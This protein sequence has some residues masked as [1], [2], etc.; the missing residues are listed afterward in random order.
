V[1]KLNPRGDLSLFLVLVLAGFAIASAR[2]ANASEAEQA[3]VVEFGPVTIDGISAIQMSWWF[4]HIADENG[5]FFNPLS[6]KNK[7]IYWEQSLAQARGHTGAV[8]VA[9]RALDGRIGHTRV[10]YDDWKKPP[11]GLQFPYPAPQG[12]NQNAV[13]LS[14]DGYVLGRMIVSYR[15]TD[16]G[17]V[18]LK[19]LFVNN[20]MDGPN[21]PESRKL[22]GFAFSDSEISD[23]WS[24]S[25]AQFDALSKFLPG[26]FGK[27]TQ[28]DEARK[29]GFTIVAVVEPALMPGV[30]SEMVYWFFNHFGDEPGKIYRA[31][32]PKVHRASRWLISP[33]DILGS[34]EIP[35]DRIVYGAISSNI[36]RN[37]SDR[38]SGKGAM[39]YPPEAGP[40][41]GWYKNHLVLSPTIPGDDS[42]RDVFLIHSW[43]DAPGGV[44]W[45]T[46]R[47]MRLPLA[48]PVRQSTYQFEHSWDEAGAV[49]SFLPRLYREANAED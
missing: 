22:D 26:W 32:A 15:N 10:F 9:E 46:G 25:R 38:H 13:F 8:Y 42:P 16:S 20:L 39:W 41:K 21:R 33:Q 30:S 18:E 45:H 47:F 37:R 3:R 31:W 12:H 6:P 11:M 34:D 1:C 27:A 4:D 14:D 44:V 2:H 36:Q 7:S 24:H 29:N 28:D 17:D 19:L 35:T 43:Q 5:A 48:E 40:V 23:F 49:S